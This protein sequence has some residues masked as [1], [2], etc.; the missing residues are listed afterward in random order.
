MVR[1]AEQSS[2]VIDEGAIS[3]LL[4]SKLSNQRQTV[5][6][7]TAPRGGARGGEIRRPTDI[8]TRPAKRSRMPNSIP[9]PVS[10][11]PDTSDYGHNDKTRRPPNAS[12]DPTARAFPCRRRKSL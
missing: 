6:S 11:P 2:G 10:A 4:L 12:V 8:D 5:G 1:C 3:A 9:P 7:A